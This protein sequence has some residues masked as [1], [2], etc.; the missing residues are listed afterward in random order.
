M[1]FRSTSSHDGAATRGLGREF[2]LL[3][4]SI[5][6]LGAGLSVLTNARADSTPVA[7]A[8]HTMLRRSKAVEG[9][10]YY[11]N[12]RKYFVGFWIVGF[13]MVGVMLSAWAWGQQRTRAHGRQLP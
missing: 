9:E 11:L 10:D 3:V 1:L 8:E 2:A 12:P 6:L 13:G 4:A 5:T 7:T